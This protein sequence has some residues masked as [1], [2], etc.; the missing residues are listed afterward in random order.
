MK[1][2]NFVYNELLIFRPQRYK[3]VSDS[4]QHSGKKESESFLIT[5]FIPDVREREREL[6]SQFRNQSFRS[7]SSPDYIYTVCTVH[8]QYIHCIL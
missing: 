2:R 6:A 7:F 8:I 4:V 1:F 3:G 5:K